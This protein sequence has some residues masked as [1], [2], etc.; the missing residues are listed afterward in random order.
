MISSELV[1]TSSDLPAGGADKDLTLDEALPLSLGG[2]SDGLTLSSLSFPCVLDASLSDGGDGVG[3]LGSSKLGDGVS[4]DIFS[5]E[6]GLVS[7]VIK[8]GDWLDFGLS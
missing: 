7:S 3:D 4:L 1:G 8:A 6:D 2:L 5:G